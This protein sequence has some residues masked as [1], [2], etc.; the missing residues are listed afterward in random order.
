MPRISPGSGT[1]FSISISPTKGEKKKNVTSARLLEN[2]GIEGDAHGDSSLPISLLPLESFAKIRR[3]DLNVSPG[4]FA[5]NITTVGVKFDDISIG[6]RM[7]LGDTARI[8]IIQ[9][10]KRCHNGCIIRELAGD[11]IMPKE[12]I[13]A[14]VLEGG[15][16]KPG[17]PVRILRD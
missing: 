14:V 13:F 8:E 1:V 16:L 6:T 7:A 17:D 15:N 12:G 10:G 11:C 2:R 3:P 4:D 9:I 5:E